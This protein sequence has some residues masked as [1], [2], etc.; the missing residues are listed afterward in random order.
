MRH[1]TTV[2]EILRPRTPIY[3]SMPCER[4][5]ITRSRSVSNNPRFVRLARV[6]I[7]RTGNK[8]PRRCARMLHFDAACMRKQNRDRYL[9]A[10]RLANS[11]SPRN[12]LEDAS[13]L[14]RR[15]YNNR[16][17]N[18]TCTYSCLCLVTPQR[19]TATKEK[20]RTDHVLAD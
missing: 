5:V 4:T 9:S 17:L 19:L 18:N 12:S 8:D 20:K 6:C 15:K 3:L 7:P 2:I 10:K 1:H 16:A 11:G 14:G 13:A